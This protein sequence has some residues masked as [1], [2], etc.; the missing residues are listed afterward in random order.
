MNIKKSNNILKFNKKFKK[1]KKNIILKNLKL[2][3]LNNYDVVVFANFNFYNTVNISI[4]KD[5]LEKNNIKYTYI[6]SNDYKFLINKKITDL[7]ME[8][9]VNSLKMLKF[10]KD[11]FSD[12]N[13]YYFN[14][15]YRHLSC[16]SKNNYT[17]IFVW[18]SFYDILLS[19]INKDNN[20]N[21]TKNDL[22]IL[23]NN[24]K[25]NYFKLKE[26]IYNLQNFYYFNKNFNIILY[27]DY[28]NINDHVLETLKVYAKVD[29]LYLKFKSHNKLISYDYLVNNFLEKNKNLNNFKSSICN[30]TLYHKIRILKILK[31]NNTQ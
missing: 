12:G 27:L 4:F 29:P 3:F 26:N 14:L 15:F 1:L 8:F 5:I 25:N 7:K 23:Y 21:I 9:Y 19:L 17:S 20:Y 11:L 10:N 22:T 16:E 6:K 31:I 13:F 28:K 24:F 18:N 30:L 2:L